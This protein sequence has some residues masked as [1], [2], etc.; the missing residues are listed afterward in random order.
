MVLNFR[1]FT[2]SREI[3]L[4]VDCY[5]SDKRLERSE[6]LVYNEVLG[7]PGIASC[8]HRSDIYMYL[9]GVD[10]RARLF[11]DHHCVILFSRVKFSRLVS[12]AKLF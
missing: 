6:R 7:E 9:G 2:R 8:S 3:F 1:G 5:N 12:T 10:F 4:T 11:I